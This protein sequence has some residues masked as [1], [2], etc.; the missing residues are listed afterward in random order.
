MGI[1]KCCELR[2]TAQEAGSSSVNNTKRLHSF[3]NYLRP[4]EFRAL[5]TF[6]ETKNICHI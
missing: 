5:A 3:V 4:E 6:A 1:S 2:M